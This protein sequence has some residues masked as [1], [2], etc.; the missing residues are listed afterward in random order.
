MRVILHHHRNASAVYFEGNFYDTEKPLDLDFSLAFRLSRVADAEVYYEDV[1]YNPAR[2]ADEKLINFVADVDNNSGFGGVSLALIKY[3]NVK[4][5]FAGKVFDVR[6]QKLLAAQNRPLDQ[7]AAGIWHDQPREKWVRS[8]FK[9]N[10][11]IVPFET[12]RVPPS[13]I[14]RFSLCNALFVPCKQNIQMFRDSGVSIPIELIHWGVNEKLFYPVERP[15]RDT[16]TFGHMG[17]LSERKG[18]DVLVD[19]FQLAFPKEKDVK[20]ICKTSYPVY[21]FEVKDERIVVHRTPWSHED[22]MNQFFKAIDCFVFPTRGEGF[23][24][25]PLEAMATGVPAIV[26]GWSGPMEYMTSA[27]GWTIDHRMTDATL[28]N[29]KIYKEPCGDWAEPSRDHL[30]ELLRYA[31][32][33]RAETA[34]KGAAAAKYVKEEWTWEKQIGLYEGALDK[35]LR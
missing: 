10:I 26:T 28:F 24:L 27:V 8:P 5:A 22:L 31:Y 32:R 25:T 3:A 6:D 21:P 17:A 34:A 9:R 29:D 2:W 4:T 11:A 16:F 23:G 33:N 12:T 18:T 19:A 1:P 35:H 15:E 14:G 20:L 7:S 30:V 13:W